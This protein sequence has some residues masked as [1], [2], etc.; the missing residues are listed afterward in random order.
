MARSREGNRIIEA[1]DF[2]SDTQ[3]WKF[4]FKHMSKRYGREFID[5]VRAMWQANDGIQT[6][7]E[8]CEMNGMPKGF[9]EN[10]IKR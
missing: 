5:T 7:E 6:E 8:F 3:N 10:V 2:E 9:F 4:D 1:I